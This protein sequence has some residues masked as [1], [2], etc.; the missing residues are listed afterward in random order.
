MPCNLM[1]VG[2]YLS[3]CTTAAKRGHC[4][5]AVRQAAEKSKRERGMCRLCR[6]CSSYT[7][8][9]RTFVEGN[10]GE[11]LEASNKGLFRE[12]FAVCLV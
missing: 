4:A 5:V 3:P 11:M 1:C 10:R 12:Y 6:G 2:L 9:K 8:R 7:A